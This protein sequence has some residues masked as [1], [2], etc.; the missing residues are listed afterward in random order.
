MDLFNSILS[1]VFVL[2]TCIFVILKS[3]NNTNKFDKIL[4]ISVIA[5]I[6]NIIFTIVLLILKFKA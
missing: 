1:T 3:K 2:V 6:L 4:I 5:L